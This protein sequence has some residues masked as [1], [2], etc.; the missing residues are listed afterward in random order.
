M[1]VFKMAYTKQIYVFYDLNKENTPNVVYA[2]I[3]D[4]Y[5]KTIET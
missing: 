1:T 4:V 5:A 3:E 2:V